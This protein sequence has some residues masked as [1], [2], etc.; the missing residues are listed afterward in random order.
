MKKGVYMD[1]HERP[2]VVKY[3]NEVF[4]PLMK[5]YRVFMSRWDVE[6]HILKRVDPVLKPGEKRI[7]ALFQ[8][9]SSFHVND[10]KNTV[11]YAP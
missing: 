1:G 5:E 4:L 2:D 11:W 10:N 6:G 3:R 9:E 8:D 7:I